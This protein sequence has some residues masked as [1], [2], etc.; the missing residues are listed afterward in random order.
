MLHS[1]LSNAQYTSVLLLVILYKC[2]TCFQK[3]LAEKDSSPKEEQ[4]KGCGEKLR[5][6]IHKMVLLNFL[7]L[8][9]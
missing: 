4:S 3:V 7:L 8:Y 1:T 9:I 6:T 5:R 2:L